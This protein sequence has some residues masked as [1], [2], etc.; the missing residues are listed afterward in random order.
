MIIVVLNVFVGLLLAA[1]GVQEVVVRGV[2][3]G[4]R[5]PFVVGAIGTVV[6]LLLCLSG[7]ALWRNWRGARGLT[8]TACVLVAGF[9][10]LAAMPPPR[11]VGNAALL[12]GVGYPLI[13]IALQLRGG[14]RATRVS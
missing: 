11:Y 3:G 7:I 13:V 6:S 4:E 2:I 9:C 8:L 1:G 10:T 12:V 5:A 14:M